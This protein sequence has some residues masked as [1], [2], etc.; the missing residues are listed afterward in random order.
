MTFKLITQ[1]IWENSFIL[2]KHPSIKAFQLIIIKKT[3][4]VSIFLSLI[5]IVTATKVLEYRNGKD[6]QLEVTIDEP[7][8]VSLPSNPTTGFRWELKESVGKVKSATEDNVGKFKAGASRPLGSGGTQVF[9]FIAEEIG[10]AILTFV[11][12]RP[13][14]N[15]LDQNTAT[16]TIKIK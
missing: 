13:W 11:Y 8:E 15:N 12:K 6:N 9:S 10:E 2:A 16:I 3:M 14:G 4:K 1:L 5:L 7:F